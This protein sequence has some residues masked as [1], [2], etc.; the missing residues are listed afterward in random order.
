MQVINKY[1]ASAFDVMGT[2]E[3]EQLYGRLP[4]SIWIFSSRSA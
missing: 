1:L 3:S 4:G 2:T